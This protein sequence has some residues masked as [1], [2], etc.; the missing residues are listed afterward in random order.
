MIFKEEDCM[1]EMLQKNFS[2]EDFGVKTTGKLVSS[3]DEWPM[4]RAELATE[5]EVVNCHSENADPLN[6]ERYSEWIKLVHHGLMLRKFS[7]Y[8]AARMKFTKVIRMSDVEPVEGYL[9]KKA[10]REAFPEEIKCLEKGEMVGKMS[11]LR[12]LTPFLDKVGIMR[13][14]SRLCNAECIPST[15]RLPI[16]LPQKH[17]LTKLIVR[18]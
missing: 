10:Q 16:I 3:E 18:D 5:E 2:T 8:V 11:S 14:N 15:A 6:I 4:S 7:Q 9:Y 12:T 13:S 17:R 1:D